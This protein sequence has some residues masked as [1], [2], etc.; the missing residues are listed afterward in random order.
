[1][2]NEIQCVANFILR[3]KSYLRINL[4]AALSRDVTN[5]VYMNNGRHLEENSRA[6]QNLP[7]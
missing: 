5:A 7:V 3:R 1:M 4:Q 2:V 6:H